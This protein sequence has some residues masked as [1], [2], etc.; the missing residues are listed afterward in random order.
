MNLIGMQNKRRW[1]LL[2]PV[3]TFTLTFLA[4]LIALLG[5]NA[6]PSPASNPGSVPR[7][8]ASAASAASAADSVRTG[9]SG[10]VCGLQPQL[11]SASFSRYVD[12]PGAIGGDVTPVRY[13]LDPYPVFNGVAVDPKN[14][15]VLLGDTNRKSLMTYD[16]LTNS[17]SGEENKPL[18]R[19]VGPATLLGFVAGVAMH[20]ERREIFGVNNDVEDNMSVFSYDDKGNLHPR[21][22]LAVPHGAWG[23][24]LSESRGEIAMSIHEA[25]NAV[26]V[27]NI[28]ARGGQGPLRTIHGAN[29]GLADPHGIY[30]DDKNNEIVVANWGSW[31]LLSKGFYSG[32]W[33]NPNYVPESTV[34]PGGRNEEPSLTVYP[35][36]AEGDAKPI[37]KIQGSRTGMNWPVGID[38]DTATQEIF[39][40]NNGDTSIL[41]FDRRK[42]GNVAPNRI[43]F[44]PRTGLDRPMSVAI[45]RKNGEL[46]V[47]NFGDHTAVVFDRNVRG[48][49]APKRIIR[50]APA[51]TASCGMGNP[52]VVAYDSKRDE[53]LVPN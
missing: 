39:V 14:G 53:L 36:E 9:D 2:R 50:N 16:R 45:D 3:I 29:T 18:T 26:L 28:E 40:V 35:L 8:S 7:F 12:Y 48:N 32:D 46:W 13:I 22:G 49:A 44:G 31:N 33:T 43:I 19:V 27:Y 20:S 25:R 24:S 17:K 21:R 6:G 47:A 34:P 51:E 37:R 1:F 10:A 30:L 38:V 15:I 52:L 41:V 23:L 42:S 11:M 5:S 4:L